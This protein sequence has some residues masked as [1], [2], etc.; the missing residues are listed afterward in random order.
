MV[1]GAGELVVLRAD[2]EARND[3]AADEP[4]P[5]E[6]DTLEGCRDEEQERQGRQVIGPSWHGYF[7]GAA[8]A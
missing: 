7:S 5:P 3:P 2:V 6:G 8:L 4:E 1:N